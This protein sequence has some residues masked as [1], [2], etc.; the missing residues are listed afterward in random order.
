MIGDIGASISGSIAS[1]LGGNLAGSLSAGL[2]T[3]VSAAANA[4]AAVSVDAG[5]SAALSAGISAAGGATSGGAARP[6]DI[7]PAFSFIVQIQGMGPLRFQKV[8]GDTGGFAATMHEAPPAAPAPTPTTANGAPH[9]ATPPRSG[10]NSSSSG[11]SVNV[12]QAGQN[13]SP[14]QLPSRNWTV[15]KIKL[16]RGM[17]P[18][19]TA[20]W[21]WLLKSSKGEYDPR[22]VTVIVL[23]EEGKMAITWV[24]H[25]TYPTQ[26]KFPALDATGD[27]GTLAIEEITLAVQGIDVEFG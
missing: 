20:L 27:K 8:G 15:D 6:P 26:W 1:S 13:G 5:G 3:S 25:K 7:W 4:A 9:P 12:Q 14:T 24:F 17:A 22:E 11:G 19:G 23:D 16:T 10:A 21:S 18:D 2:S